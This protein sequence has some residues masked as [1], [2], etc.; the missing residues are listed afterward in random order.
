MT[1][2]NVGRMCILFDPQ[3]AAFA[4]FQPLPAKA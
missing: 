3:G 2:E 4:I 1:I